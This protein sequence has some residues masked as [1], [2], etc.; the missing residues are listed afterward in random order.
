M[1]EKGVFPFN[2]V[3]ATPD[4]G[5]IGRRQALFEEISASLKDVKIPNDVIGASKGLM[6]D[7]ALKIWW[8]TPNARWFQVSPQQMW[9]ARRYEMVIDYI[10]A[11]KGDQRTQIGEAFAQIKRDREKAKKR[12]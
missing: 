10:F 6:T 1:K 9:E 2:I 8:M 5:V 4:G 11:L 7:L 12:Q 3:E